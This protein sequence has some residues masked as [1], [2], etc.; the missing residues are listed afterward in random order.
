MKYAIEIDKYSGFCFG[1]TRA[2]SATES[3]L[4]KSEKIYC[5]G[6]IVHNNKEQERLKLIGLETIDYEKIDKIKNQNLIIRAHGEAPEIYKHLEANNINIIDETC[7]VVLKLQEKIKKIYSENPNSCILIFG[8]KKHPEVNGLL[9]Q[10]NNTAT[11]ISSF[12]EVKNIKIN[13]PFY[14]FAQTTANYDEYL[15]IQEYLKNFIKN[16]DSKKYFFDTIC[17]SVK[18]RI[19]QL[20]EFC[21]KHDIII[22]VSDYNSSNGKMLFEIC[23]KANPNSYFVTSELDINQEWFKGLY[24][25]GISGATSTPVWLMKKI[26]EKIKKI[27]F[28]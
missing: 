25:I 23:K 20:Q 4:N 19:P 8:K 18:K 9:G 14:L 24:S 13:F 12:D 22:F 15:K 21:K 17:P 26:E 7:P 27:F 16:D 10:T 28:F 5:L 2:I 3:F 11:I 6:N 1:V